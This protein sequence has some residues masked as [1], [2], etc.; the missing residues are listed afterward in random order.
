V[1]ADQP[2][3][4]LLDVQRLLGLD[5]DVGGGAAH[6]ARGLVHH[7][8]R[9]RQG[10]ALALRTGAEEELPHRRGQ[11]HAHRR[12]VVGDVVHRVVDRHPGVHGATRAVDV[13]E[14]VSGR[15]LGVEQEHLRADR[16]GVLVAHL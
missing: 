14:D 7:D 9:V 8:P 5:L 2:E 16:V 13:E 15:V 10:V 6:A 12:D 11:A 3:Q 1:L 4:H